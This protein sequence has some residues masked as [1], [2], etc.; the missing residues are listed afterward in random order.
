MKKKL[1]MTLVSG[2]CLSLPLMLTACNMDNGYKNGD[3]SIR[4]GIGPQTGNTGN[5]AAINEK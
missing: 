3:A 4:Q 2:A 1:L 5:H